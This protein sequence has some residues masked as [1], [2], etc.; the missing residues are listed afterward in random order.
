MRFRF[1]LIILAALALSACSKSTATSSL[2]PFSAALS[3]L[4]DTFLQQ[5]AEIPRY[6]LSLVLNPDSRSLSGRATVHYTNL[7]SDTLREVYFRLYPNMSM[8]GGRMSVTKVAVDGSEMPFVEMA[9]GSDL[10]VPLP[11]SLEPHKTATIVIDFS[12]V[13]PES[14]GDYDFFGSR[15]GVAILPEC[16]PVL[17]VLIDGEWHLDSSPGFGDAAYTDLS[18]YHL[19]ITAPAQYTI[20]APGVLADWR[21][22]SDG[23]VR[24]FVTGPTRTIGVIAGA[25]YQAQEL[26][27]GSV[28]LTGYA[29]TA[30]AA[31]MSAALDHAA[32]MLAFCTDNLGPYHSNAL[33][34]VQAPLAQ[35]DLHL[36]GLAIINQPYFDELRHESGSAVALAVSREWWGT[37]VAFDPLRDPWLDE[38]LAS[39]TAYLYE[40]AGA[41]EAGT[42]SW[43]S[44]WGEAYQEA[45]VTGQ[46]S[47]LGQPLS[48]YGNSSR[49]ELLVHSQGPLFWRDLEN[50]LGETG[51]M[52]VLREIQ[53]STDLGHLDSDG[54]VAII[55]R[56]VG[57]PGLDVARSWGL[58]VP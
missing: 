24:T 12:L 41:G 4:P 2:E 26:R 22:T 27:S 28:T 32:A 56:L 37:Q 36:G 10:K 19:E 30:D 1:L 40:R 33:T 13:Y 47:L 51:L 48:A 45:A 53:R 58:S 21:T 54:L 52:A 55:A 17:A 15:E 18:L 7:A 5:L 9:K 34:L 42:A 35:S 20:V 25:G 57:E 44:A 6:H 31:S 39:Y 46:T 16:Y 14:T 50:L 49:Y 3:G 38:S 23:V 8:Y 11:Q 43:A 29:R